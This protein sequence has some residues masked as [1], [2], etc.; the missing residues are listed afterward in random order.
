MTFD[1]APIGVLAPMPPELRPLVRRLRLRRPRGSPVHTGQL[2]GLAIV[3]TTTG[4]GIER[5]RRAT[6]RLIDQYRVR[7]VL[8]LG[9]AGGLDPSLA[10]GDVVVPEVVEAADG[11]RY[12]AST[13]GGPVPSGC[14]LSDD[15]LVK[16][17]AAL[18]GL[19]RRGVTALDM[20]TAG[21]AE[22]CSARG[23]GWSAYRGIS[24]QALDPSVDE[25]ILGLLR[26]DGSAD[27][28]RVARLIGREPRRLASLVRLGRQLATATGA[29]ARTAAAAL[30]AAA[31]A[32]S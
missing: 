30:G 24:D 9:V 27:L 11:T 20:E 13:L 12:S 26:P 22:V 23:V 7:H 21:V 8:V 10:I 29:A 19:R 1:P 16:D 17:P 25:A 6:S 5:A 14:I 32:S 31:A 28:G 2:G 3:A 15:Q 18:A 4:V